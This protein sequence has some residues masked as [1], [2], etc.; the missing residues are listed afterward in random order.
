MSLVDGTK[1]MNLLKTSQVCMNINMQDISCSSSVM[2]LGS[3]SYSE[4]PQ[5]LTQRLSLLS[6]TDEL[7]R[8]CAYWQ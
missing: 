3:V 5:S 8:I 7:L 4:S 2:I 1:E 6:G